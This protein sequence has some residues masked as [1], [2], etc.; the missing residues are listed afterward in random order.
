MVLS[1]QSQ[2]VHFSSVSEG[3]ELKRKREDLQARMRAAARSAE[4]HED[5]SLSPY[6]C[7]ACRTS[8]GLVEFSGSRSSVARRSHLKI[9]DM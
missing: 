5:G 2:L 4:Y 7:T 8:V 6:G 9:I 1:R 3:P